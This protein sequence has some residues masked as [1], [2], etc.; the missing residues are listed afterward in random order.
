MC[1]SN[2]TPAERSELFA[3]MCHM[4]Y[5]GKSKCEEMCRKRSLPMPEIV[6]ANN[7]YC[8]VFNMPHDT[9]V[10]VRGV[11]DATDKKST[12]DAIHQETS[13]KNGY[14]HRGFMTETQNL[15]DKLKPFPKEKPLWITGF[16]LGGAIALILASVFPVKEL[17]TFGAPRTGNF[18]WVKAYRDIVHYRWVN[19]N[20]FIPRIPRIIYKHHGTEM[21]IKYDGTIVESPRGMDKF[22][23]RVKGHLFAYLSKQTKWDFEHD[24]YIGY[25]HDHISQ[26][27]KNFREVK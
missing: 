1:L 8:I 22:I 20:D 10:A 2:K 21:Y 18:E 15:L 16:S 25:Y 3:Y 9:V 23:D 24:H 17:H 13:I 19:N 12:I 4:C 11:D 7:A 26:Y 27:N 6:E 14:I 5:Y